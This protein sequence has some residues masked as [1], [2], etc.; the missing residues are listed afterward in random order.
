M[1][2]NVNVKTDSS[3]PVATRSVTYSGDTVNIGTSLLAIITGGAD[4]AKTITDAPG[5]AT[6]GFDVDVTR[7]PALAAGTNNIGDVDVLTVPAPLSTT[8]NGTAATALR[9]TVAS[10]STGTVAVTATNL[11]TNI[12][13]MNGTAVTMGN[14]A[15]GTGVQRVTIA[16]DSTGQVALAAGSNLIGAVNLRPAT[17][18]G[19]TYHNKVA[20]AS[21]NA[22]NVKASA[23]QIGGWYIY[24]NNT[25]ARKVAFHN[26]SGTPT[27]GTSVVFSLI[28]PGS[29]AANVAF[30][31]GIQF[32]TGIA[33][34]MVTVP[35]TPADS[36]ST[37]VAAGDL[38]M[39]LLYN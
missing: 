9:V 39:L 32:S 38:I 12:A 11:S 14:G 35:A 33:Y 18:N 24:N 20:A 16:S 29:S 34:T 28:I 31:N 4:D 21:T 6:Y 10:D 30:P 36:D 25:S 3:I 17:A 8:G 15:S 37:A 1:P 2:D 5:D 26:T 7:L 13:Q 19:W 27:A 22:T 23:G